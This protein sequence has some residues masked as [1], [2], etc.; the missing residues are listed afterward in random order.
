MKKGA[1]LILS[2]LKSCLISLQPYPKAKARKTGIIMVTPPKI[3]NMFRFPPSKKIFNSSLHPKKSGFAHYSFLYWH[4]WLTCY[5][6]WSVVALLSIK[7]WH[8]SLTHIYVKLLLLLLDE[9]L[10]TKINYSSTFSIQLRVYS[11]WIIPC[12]KKYVHKL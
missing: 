1:K 7:Y 5:K 8:F 3:S 12:Q 11:V 6:K 9:V 2:S 4:W 10:L